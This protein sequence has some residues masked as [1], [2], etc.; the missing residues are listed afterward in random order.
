[1]PLVKRD[2]EIRT[3]NT[4]KASRT[5]P[6]LLEQLN[7]ETPT[8]RRW[9]ARD[10]GQHPESVFA[11]C[12]RL[13]IEKDIIVKEM[14]FTSLITIHNP[15]SVDGLFDLLRNE[16]A[17]LRNGA[18]DAL[19][20]M[21]DTVA[22]RLHD[23]LADD[24]VDVRIFAVNIMA[25]LRNTNV[26][27]WLMQVLRHESDVNVCATVIDVIRELDATEAIPDLS[28]LKEKFH[29]EPF[30]LFAVDMA[31]GQL[32]ATQQTTRGVA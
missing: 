5:Y 24:D 13:Q 32:Q 20:V 1:M 31:L 29:S 23:L 3:P 25:S 26:V 14:I 27:D 15:E 28:R 9:A 10:L 11:L 16:D 21:S 2:K 6:F 30:I 19:K 7:T 18:A 22:S 4:R 17:Y 8:E 12:D